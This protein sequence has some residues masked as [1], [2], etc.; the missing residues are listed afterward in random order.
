MLGNHRTCLDLRERRDSC[1][2]VTQKLCAFCGPV[3][4]L[5]LNCL[6]AARGSAS[7]VPKHPTPPPPEA[8]TLFQ[9][10][11]RS[12]AELQLPGL[13]PA[14]TAP[15]VPSSSFFTMHQQKSL[16]KVRQSTAAVNFYETIHVKNCTPRQT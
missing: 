6:K 7:Q 12:K 9:L 5:P 4:D 15:S 3:W 2:H 14:E 13:L 8:Q 11:S 10:N 16:Y 1:Q